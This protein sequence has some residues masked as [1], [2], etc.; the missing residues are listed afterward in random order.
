M[1]IQHAVDG[2]SEFCDQ[3]DGD[4]VGEDCMCIVITY[5]VLVFYSLGTCSVLRYKLITKLLLPLLKNVFNDDT[6]H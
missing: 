4:V 5:S 1:C 6:E 2:F 3:C